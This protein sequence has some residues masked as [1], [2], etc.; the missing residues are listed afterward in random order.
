MD[1]K[2]TYGTKLIRKIQ[3]STHAFKECSSTNGISDH[4]TFCG[5]SDLLKQTS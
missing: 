4:A 5:F 2:T 3:Y 1:K